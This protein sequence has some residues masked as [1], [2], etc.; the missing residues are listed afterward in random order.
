MRQV[1]S[2]SGCIRATRG[3]LKLGGGQIIKL[4]E[5]MI[6]AD[7]SGYTNSDRLKTIYHL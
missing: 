4:T 6:A 5:D 1:R 7:G 3:Q 2:E